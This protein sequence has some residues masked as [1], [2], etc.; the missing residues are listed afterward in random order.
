MTDQLRGGVPAPWTETPDG[1]GDAPDN[2]GPAIS[3]MHPERMH[4]AEDD[5]E[6]RATSPEFHERPA[7]S[8]YT[9]PAA[10]QDPPSVAPGRRAEPETTAETG[11]S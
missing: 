8:D 2:D 7:A 4:R 6:A 1:P 11:R 10:T 3:P 5:D 9:A